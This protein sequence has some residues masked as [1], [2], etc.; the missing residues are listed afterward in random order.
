MSKEKILIV[1]DD[2]VTSMF[3]KISLEKLDYEVV[4]VAHDTFQARNKI[5]IYEPDLILLDISLEDEKDGI[6]LAAYIQKNH[7]IP[8]IYLSSHAEDEILDEAKLTK[9]YGYIVKPFEPKSLHSSIQMAMY[10]FQEE[11]KMKKEINKYEE[12]QENLEKLLYNKKISNKPIVPFAS[13]YHL[14]IS[15]CE[16]FYQD[17]KLKLTKKENAFIRILVSQL[18]QVVS[19][20]QVMN[21]VWEDDSATENSIRTLVWRLRKKLPSDIIKTSSGRG[22]YIEA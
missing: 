19:F 8:F 13:K 4:A 14:D 6:T 1:E 17:E 16:T 18:G 20:D 11:L 10:K 5:K 21:Y 9:P 15:V 7:A 2:E 3:L 22:Y 12:K